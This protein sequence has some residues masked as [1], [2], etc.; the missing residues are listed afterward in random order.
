MILYSIDPSGLSELDL[1]GFFRGVAFAA[2]TRA[3]P[4]GSWWQLSVSMISDGVL[5]A[6]IPWLLTCDERLR[7]LVLSTSGSAGT[8]W[9]PSH[10][11]SS[12][13]AYLGSRPRS[14]SHGHPS[15]VV[16]RCGLM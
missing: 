4:C 3:A 2:D 11:N 13:A 15:A 7:P 8:H 16:S 5:T 12:P 1:S 6:F 9:A 10:R 14:S